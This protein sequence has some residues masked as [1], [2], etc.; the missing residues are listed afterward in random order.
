MPNRPRRDSGLISPP[1]P[2]LPPPLPPLPLL[3]LLLLLLLLDEVAL[4]NTCAVACADCGPDVQ[5]SV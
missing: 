3:L 1:P 4:L 2:L 5:V